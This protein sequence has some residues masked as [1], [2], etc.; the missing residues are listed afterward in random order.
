MRGALLLRPPLP[1]LLLLVCSLYVHDISRI[2]Y[3]IDG[4]INHFDFVEVRARDVCRCVASSLSLSCN[5]YIYIARKMRVYDICLVAGD[6]VQF[7]NS[8]KFLFIFFPPDAT[9]S[10]LLPLAPSVPSTHP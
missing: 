4:I 2:T 6:C 10:Y 5:Q 7:L 3:R 9:T 8:M 1:L